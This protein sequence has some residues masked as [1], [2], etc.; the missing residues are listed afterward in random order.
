MEDSYVVSI[1]RIKFNSA[2]GDLMT[3]NHQKVHYTLCY[4]ML[5]VVTGTCSFKV[6]FQTGL[7]GFI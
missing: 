5:L 6:I 1:L 4:V 7:N 2:C 3:E